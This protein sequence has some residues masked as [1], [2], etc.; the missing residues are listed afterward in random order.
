MFIF[1]KRGMEFDRNHIILSN[2]SHAAGGFGL[3]IL[4][5]HYLVGNEFA[6]MW[7]AVV[8]VAFSIAAHLRAVMK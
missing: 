6:P 2:A 7:V 1:V 5:Q 3:A 8:L 4:L